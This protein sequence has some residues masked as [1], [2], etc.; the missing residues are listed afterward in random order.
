M[1]PDPTG[2]PQGGDGDRWAS[3]SRVSPAAQG[4]SQTETNRMQVRQ[5]QFEVLSTNFTRWVIVFSLM[6][7]IM[8]PV[9][10]GLFV[11]LIISYL[12]ESDQDC[13]VPLRE[14]VW[15]VVSNI[16]YHTNLC[17]AGSMHTLIL[18]HIFRYDPQGTTPSKWYVKVYNVLVTMLIFVWHCVGLHWVRISVTCEEKSPNLFSSIKVFA[19]FSVVFNIFVYI[20]TVGLYTIMMFMLRNG[21][22][23]ADTAAPAG[24]LDDQAV[25]KYEPELFSDIKECCIC[26]VDFD[27]ETEIR[28][29]RCGHVYH[30]KCLAGWLKV[31]RTCPL[32]R[33]DLSPET[34]SPETLGVDNNPP[35]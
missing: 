29:T 24:T 16:L 34:V 35:V 10:L 28:R 1:Q 18:K 26:T 9:M 27:A 31:N 13:D 2:D 7:F 11:W 12:R 25:V 22:L 5:H 23:S 19:A 17:G 20:N 14:W 6:L 21:M 15:V 3:P 33:T 4:L 32:C 8:L 30:G